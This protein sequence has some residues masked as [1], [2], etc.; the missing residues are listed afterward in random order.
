MVLW[1]LFFPAD[2]RRDCCADS[3]STAG[4]DH[5]VCAGR[6]SHSPACCARIPYSAIEQQ[7]DHGGVYQYIIAEHYQRGDRGGYNYYIELL[8]RRHSVSKYIQIRE[9]DND[10][11]TEFLQT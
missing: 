9:Y 4:A 7:E 10:K 3:Q 6:R 11:D 8:R 2:K 1:F 5:P